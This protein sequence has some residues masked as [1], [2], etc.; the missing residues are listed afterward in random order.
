MENIE[1]KPPGGGSA[2]CAA[3]NGAIPTPDR[4]PKGTG[5]DHT[6]PRPEEGGNVRLPHSMI[7]SRPANSSDGTE[8]N[9]PCPLRRHRPLPRPTRGLG[10]SAGPLPAVRRRNRRLLEGPLPRP[11]PNGNRPPKRAKR[12][13]LR[14]DFKGWLAALKGLPRPA[15]Y[16]R[17]VRAQRI[18][19][20]VGDGWERLTA[21][22]ED[23]LRTRIDASPALRDP[24]VST[25]VQG[26]P[27]HHECQVRLL[28]FRVIVAP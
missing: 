14:Q 18:E 26:G 5:A 10:R 7:G 13:R 22:A 3:E 19:L 16:R 12:R 15:R 9:G 21:D 11:P 4:P 6:A 2:P 24:P 8:W 27:A 20:D 25:W 1:E 23:S 28:L 17:N